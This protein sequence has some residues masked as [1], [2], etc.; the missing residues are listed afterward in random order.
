MCAQRQ[1][2]GHYL[3]RFE[4]CKVALA[5]VYLGPKINRAAGRVLENLLASV[6]IGQLMRFTQDCSANGR[7]RE[8]CEGCEDRCPNPTPNLWEKAIL[9]NLKVT[10]LQNYTG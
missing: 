4:P 10:D 5:R 3:L 6:T 7:D 1:V 2:G 8:E 9:Q